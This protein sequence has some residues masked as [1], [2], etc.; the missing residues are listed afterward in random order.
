MERFFWLSLREDVRK[1]IRECGSCQP[2]KNTA[3]FFRAPLMPILP[4]DADAITCM[5]YAGPLSKTE[6]DHTGI[7]V[8]VSHFM[9]FVRLYPVNDMTAISHAETV[10]TDSLR[11]G[12]PKAVLTD[13]GNDH[14]AEVMEHVYDLLDIRLLRT[15]QYHPQTDGKAEEKIQVI[16][17]M[18]I[19][20][21]NK[22]Q[23]DWD[24]F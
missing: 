7:R 18:L 15:T 19:P 12:L 20:F 11:Y 16:K 10:V 13:R 8:V 17:Q 9:G 23:D 2:L 14:Q 4:D 3:P 22:H 1:Y 24:Q 21:I 5:D 6:R